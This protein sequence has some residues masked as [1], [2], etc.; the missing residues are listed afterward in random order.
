[1]V[2]EKSGVLMLIKS[3]TKWSKTKNTWK[4]Q[5]FTIEYFSKLFP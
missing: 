3:G 2:F 1:M 5:A 4:N